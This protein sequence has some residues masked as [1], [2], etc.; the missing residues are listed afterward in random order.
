[1]DE[2][3]TKT[4]SKYLTQEQIETFQN[5]G[6]IVIPNILTPQ[7]IQTSLEKLQKTLLQYGVDTN[8]L[9]ATG[10]NLVQLSSTNGS[11]GV[12]DLFYPGFRLDIATNESLFQATCELWEA[13]F[14][15]KKNECDSNGSGEGGNDDHE[16]GN[17]NMKNNDEEWMYHPFG[18]FDCDKGYAY[19]DRIGYRLPTTMS[20]QIGQSIQQQQIE[21][22]LKVKKKKKSRSAIQRSL[23]PH[24]DCCPDTI[25]SIEQKSKW[26][27]IQCFVSLTDNLQ[28]NTGGFEAVRG[29]FH[30]EF[31]SWASTRPNTIMKNTEISPPCI[32]EYTH[33]RPKEDAEVFS[34]VEHIP[35]TAGSAVLWDNRIPHANA[36]KN[37]SSEPR[38]V[39]YC[40]FLP[41]VEVNR[42]YARKQLEDYKLG[43]IPRDQWID[44]EK[45]S[46]KSTDSNKV[47]NDKNKSESN[48]NENDDGDIAIYEEFHDVTSY[49]FS[50]LGRKLMMIDEW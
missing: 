22:G 28:P 12:L 18:D 17:D 46:E 6:I 9:Q 20:E 11:G 37:N 15:H 34:R 27:P 30:K 39:V 24:L 35:V 40:S 44:R 26:R 38:I 32:G 10:H 33:M 7:Q 23:T 31:N 1:M 21:Q 36:Y 47:T 4:K 16:S 13:S 49:K 3:N 14:H 45:E 41:D 19:I 25:H 2:T 29:G 42:I 8:D 43:R 5:D 48:N 50:K